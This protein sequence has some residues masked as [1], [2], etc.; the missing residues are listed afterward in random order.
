MPSR[1]PSPWMI[2]LPAA[3]ALLAR[4]AAAQ[5]L[6]PTFCEVVDEAG[7]AVAGAEVTLVGGRPELSADLQEVHVVE[8]A[9]GKRGRVLA[10]LRPGLCYVAWAKGP[11]VDA[12][13]ASAAVVG[14]FAAGA[15]IQLRCGAPAPIQTCRVTGADAWSDGPS[16][17]YYAITRIP[18]TEREV[19]LDEDGCFDAPG[20]PFDH[21][22]VRLP[23]GQ[24]LWSAPIQ[25]LLEVP[26]PQRVR[27][28]A[29]DERGRPLA[30]AV[31]SHRV[32]RRSSWRVDG[33]RSVGEERMRQ[34]GVADADGLCDVIVPY[35]GDP[36]Q[37][38]DENLL[39]F[40]S[41]PERPPVAGGVW[42]RG[43][44]VSDRKV[45]AIEGDELRFDCPAVAPLRGAVPGA[46]RGTVAH[47]SAIC[48]LHL[49]RNSYLHDAR[50]FTA[51]V[52]PDGSF[53]FVD[54]PLELHSCRLAFLPPA[55]SD[56]QPPVYPPEA[57]RTLP[58][59]VVVRLDS[60]DP[61]GFGELRL[62]VLDATGG[63]ARGAVAL[64]SS[65]ERSGVLLR[66]SVLRVPLDERGQARL[67]AQPGRWVVVVVT[68]DGFGGEPVEVGAAGGAFEM[69]LR[70]LARTQVTLLD[71]RG[72]PVPG[73][74]VRS[75]GTS[76]R[77]TN[78]PVRSTLQGLRV[79]T[80]MQ[81]GALRTDERGRVEI[82]F[83]PVEGV[84]QRVELRWE[85]GRSEEF[86]LEVEQPVTARP[87]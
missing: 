55:G 81:W 24:P 76:T 40:V 56:W 67:R 29:V 61:L 42:N 82:P 64:L 75:R 41:A 7:A 36:L 79:T 84:R 58:D 35:D 49:Q 44:Y 18:G 22:E 46:P 87:R 74:R 6:R 27:V 28:R 5:Q 16:L 4:S 2:L 9:T 52:Q 60:E 78:D 68:A 69:Q 10:R 62:Q 71:E 32:T 3:L 73:A 72:A 47:L 63:P 14:Y 25:D 38:P 77:G 45:A 59:D 11:V 17:R 66:D 80:Q 8:V 53:A 15:M 50:V 57:R 86:E 34:L 51:D 26:P 37:R 1:S 85:G 39:L 21:L 83:V 31:V 20:A 70:P 33:L 13:R 19:T 43:Y 48:K 12:Q 54:V 30:G 65:A 23:D